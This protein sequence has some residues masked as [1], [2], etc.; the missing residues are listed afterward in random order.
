[1]ADC[2][3]LENKLLCSLLVKISFPVPSFPQL[4]EILLVGLRL[5]SFHFVMS[6]GNYTCSFSSRMKRHASESM[7]VASVC[8]VAKKS[9]Q[10]S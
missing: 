3:T 6:V 9:F 4:P 2:W 7:S 5:F 1:M 10:S 8:I